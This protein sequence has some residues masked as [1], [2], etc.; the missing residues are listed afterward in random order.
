M[1][2]VRLPLPD[3]RFPRIPQDASAAESA[4][5]L[6]LLRSHCCLSTAVPESP[7]ASRRH[8]QTFAALAVESPRPVRA[9]LTQKMWPPIATLP[10]TPTAFQTT[11][12]PPRAPALFVP[13]SPTTV[14]PA[15]QFP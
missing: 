4:Q 9:G 2:E 3:Q 14:A 1:A 11:A 10:Q 5:R 13:I 8:S 7:V 15:A 6:E 12:R